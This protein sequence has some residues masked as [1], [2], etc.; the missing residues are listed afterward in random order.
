M[1]K[2]FFERAL[3]AE[4]WAKDVL[5]ETGTEG[6]IGNIQASASPAGA[7]HRGAIGLP[8][9]ANLHSHAFQRGMAGLAE[10]AGP[11]PDSFWTW[12]QVLYRFPERL[13]PEDVGAIASQ[14]HVEMAEAGFT[15]VRR[16]PQL[17]PPRPSHR[18]YAEHRS[19]GM[20]A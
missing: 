1:G 20:V 6:S 15:S 14:L 11:T 2:L 13:A 8:G 17:P 18:D 5:I 19:Y 4:G 9:L 3:L 10:V 7:D 16:C 12:R